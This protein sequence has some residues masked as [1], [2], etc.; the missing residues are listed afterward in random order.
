MAAYRG[1]KRGLEHL[2]E[3]EPKPA[4]QMRNL[5]EKMSE[6]RLVVVLEGATLETVKVLQLYFKIIHLIV[7]TVQSRVHSGFIQSNVS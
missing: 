4:K 6:K 1:G 5:H 3:Y 2:D 7:M